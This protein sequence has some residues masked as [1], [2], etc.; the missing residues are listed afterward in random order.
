M[1]HMLQW[2]DQLRLT[3]A[4]VGYSLFSVA[5]PAIAQTPTMLTG[6]EN[7]K[8]EQAPCKLVGR[9]TVEGMDEPVVSAK[10]RVLSN[11][12]KGWPFELQTETAVTDKDGNY[13][14]PLPVGQSML[15][16]IV[17]PPGY[18]TTPQ[19]GVLVPTRAEPVVT[20][21]FVVQRGTPWRVRLS[22]ENETKSPGKQMFYALDRDDLVVF[23]NS[24]ESDKRGA[25]MLTFP[26]EGG[27]FEIGC[28]D[29]SHSLIHQKPAV[30][31][32]EDLFDPN[33]VE[34][35]NRGAKSGEE[36]LVD[37]DGRTARI[38]GASFVVQNKVA[39]IV[40]TARLD[41]SKSEGNVAGSVIDENGAPLKD[42]RVALAIAGAERNTLLA[43]HFSALTDAGGKFSIS[44]IPTSGAAKDKL[45]LT[46]IVT[47]HGY[48]GIDTKPI[49]F[50]P[51]AHAIEPVR[52]SPEIAAKFQ[53]VDADEVPLEGAWV[54]PTGSFAMRSQSSKTDRE[55]RCL[56]SGLN[57]G[58]TEV[59][60]LFGYTG[61]VA[62][63]DGSKDELYVKLPRTAKAAAVP[64][65]QRR[66]VELK[67]GELAPEWDVD[68]WLNAR[69][70][71]LA[72]FRGKVVVLDFW[73]AWCEPCLQA[74]PM[75]K[76]L[77]AKY[78]DKDVVFIGIHSAGT[79]VEQISKLMAEKEW[80]FWTAR[81]AG[82]V[83]TIGKTASLY[84]VRT[85][86]TIVVID[87]AGKVAYNSGLDLE[88]RKLKARTPTFAKSL[89]LSWPFD[90][91]WA[92]EKKLAWLSQIQQAVFSEKID[93]ALNKK[94][95]SPAWNFE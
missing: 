19:T 49:S 52:L 70:R 54:E 89:K 14:L 50:G 53:V 83:D 57:R 69:T 42:A 9:V 43:E 5:T 17:C 26:V 33:R 46:I 25:G 62:I 38:T 79:E 7:A 81:D 61:H 32:F 88:A 3:F 4:I 92:D 58:T 10:V 31:E 73:G 90:K 75:M 11:K 22:I 34:M 8:S 95:E 27:K 84:G 20:R 41:D 16:G 72:D 18:W 76:N 28:Q 48:G 93:A 24:V 87:R 30:F 56:I 74:I 23:E 1:V 64:R 65:T 36:S 37:A 55:G 12:S 29:E 51:G 67:A 59:T 68:T 86:P 91:S 94:Q 63:V 45:L 80:D 21:S 78:A 71:P 13:A 66:T 82:G 39:E 35:V 6:Q 47:K 44:H 77:Q 60:V 15:S 40:L 85:W 2:R